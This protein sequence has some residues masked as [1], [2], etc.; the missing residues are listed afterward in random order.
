MLLAGSLI[1]TAWA[2]SMIGVDYGPA[3]TGL[4]PDELAGAPG[5]R[6]GNWN[7]AAIAGANTTLDLPDGAIMDNSGNIVNGLS[8]S[9]FTGNAGTSSTRGN[10]PGGTAP[11]LAND[12]RM[13]RTVTDKYEGAEG[14]ITITGIP[15]AKY[16][17]YFYVYPDSGSGGER[18]GYFTVTNSAGEVQTRWLKGGTGISTTI[19]LPDPATGDG[20]IQ[21]KTSL[22][23]T[24]FAGIE[25]G[26]Y[27]VLSG[28]TD[29]NVEVHY[30]AVGFGAGGV[31]G[32]E[33]NRRLKFSGFQIVEVTSSG[34]TSLSLVSPIPWLYPGNPQGYATAVLGLYQDGS[35]VPLSTLGGATYTS[36]ITNVFTV[37]SDGLVQP[38][39]PGLANLVVSYQGMSLTQEISVIQPLAVR[40]VITTDPILRGATLQA[41]LLADF[42]D[43]K[44]DVNVTQFNGVSFGGGSPGVATVSSSGLVSAIGVGS[45]GLNATYAGVTDQI[46]IPYAVQPY[47]APQPDQGVAVSFSI[48]AGNPMLFTDLAGAP[49]VRVGYWNNIAGLLASLNTV[50]LGPNAVVD[51]T[52][53]VISAMSVS[54]TGGSSTAGSSSRGTQSGNE[55]TMFNGVYDQFNGT[56][57]AI[58]VTNIPF[59]VYD[60]YLYVLS[61]DAGNRPGHFT[62][63]NETRWVLDTIDLMIPDNS[64]NGYVEAIT[65][66]APTAVAEVQPGN[67]VKFSNLKESS[68][69]V[70]FVADNASTIVDAD[71]AAPRLK[72]AGFQLVGTLAPAATPTLQVTW[73][74]GT[75]LRLAWPASATGYVLKSNTVLNGIWNP[76]NATAVPD[77]DNLTVTVPI[78]GSSAFYILQKP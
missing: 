32:G 42:S 25:A 46:D 43:G 16:Q 6:T 75:S 76:V 48:Q 3:E 27:V 24:N 62:V 61:G 38:G 30:S 40:P 54:V 19:P 37:N 18:G 41:A 51:S 52:G 60:L 10:P 29:R 69:T 68:L 22:Q 63:G 53:K 4:L 20:Y 44:T 36:S 65:T 59:A 55:S 67:Y 12:G 17:L 58:L 70:Q 15:F 35:T 73:A 74:G 21:S 49:G 45:F 33:A 13:F 7:A 11:D 39:N 34:M 14:I 5:G 56:P 31:A 28:L 66:N 8:M 47:D 72:F 77:G 9:L 71:N 2:A 26:H 50:V 57:G 23:P 1:T 64:G 78:S